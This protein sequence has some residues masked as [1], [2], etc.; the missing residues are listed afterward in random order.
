[1]VHPHNEIPASIKKNEEDPHVLI[2]INIQ[3][4]LLSER[5]KKNSLLPFVNKSNKHTH[6]I[7]I[8]IYIYLFVFA[9]RTLEEKQDIK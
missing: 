7:E 6:N 2:W 4:I 5:R 1:M 3:D 9:K 8:Q